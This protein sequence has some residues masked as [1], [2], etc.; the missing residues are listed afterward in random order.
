[1]CCS[2]VDLDRFEKTDECKDT[3]VR[4]EQITGSSPAKLEVRAA[5]SCVWGSLSFTTKTVRFVNPK[6]CGVCCRHKKLQGHV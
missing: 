3:S 4:Y 6:Q 5:S 2:R 1:M